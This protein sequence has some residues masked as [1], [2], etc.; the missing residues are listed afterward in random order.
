MPQT[1][2]AQ[3]TRAF[4]LRRRQVISGLMA[5]PLAFGCIGARVAFAEPLQDGT[6]RSDVIALLVLVDFATPQ[7]LPALPGLG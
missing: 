2:T 3:S 7:T 5:A 6:F 1:P 4:D